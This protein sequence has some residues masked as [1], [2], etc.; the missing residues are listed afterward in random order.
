MEEVFIM[1]LA[2]M[3]NWPSDWD[4]W[5]WSL[6]SFWSFS[7]WHV[8]SSGVVFNLEVDSKKPLGITHKMWPKTHKKE[9]FPTHKQRI[10]MKPMKL[11]RRRLQDHHREQG[12]KAYDVTKLEF[13]TQINKKGKL[14]V[15][16]QFS[17]E[18]NNQI[19]KIAFFCQIA[20]FWFFEVTK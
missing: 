17:R 9:P 3:L 2:T 8:C 12:I 13:W 7:L 20:M 18:K 1:D 14:S 15:T 11:R 10:G 16:K 5:P 4:K 6:S 19:V